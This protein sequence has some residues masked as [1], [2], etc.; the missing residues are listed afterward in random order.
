MKRIN[1]LQS[2]IIALCMIFSLFTLQ[3]SAADTTENLKDVLTIFDETADEIPEMKYKDVKPDDWF[4]AEVGTMYATGLMTGKDEAGEIFAPYENV[5]RAQF[6][7]MIYRFMNGEEILKAYEEEGYVVENPFTDVEDDAWY[8]DAIRF[9]AEM[10]IVKGYTDTGKFG[11]GEDINREQLATMLYRMGNVVN[12]ITDQIVFDMEVAEPEEDFM[13]YEDAS[14]V[15]KFAKDAM[16]WA[17]GTGIVDG[18]YEGTQLDP[19]GTASRAECAIMMTRFI[20]TMNENAHIPTGKV[21]ETP[22]TSGT[23]PE[24]PET[25]VHE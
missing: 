25:S 14:S 9:A 13:K 8:T 12:E 21:P 5:A 11:P 19:Q 22:D 2:M 7:M 16:V 18:K 4:Y 17:V 10:E 3:V 1:K 15:N 6:A 24:V 20:M 23:T